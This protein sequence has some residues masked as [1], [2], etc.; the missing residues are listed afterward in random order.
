MILKND[1][2]RALYLYLCFNFGDILDQNGIVV[3]EEASICLSEYLPCD[4]NRGM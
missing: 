1:L 4:G 2:E 3:L